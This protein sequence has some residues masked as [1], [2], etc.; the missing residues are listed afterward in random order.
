[1]IG[2]QMEG[3]TKEEI[4][5]P[6]YGSFVLEIDNDLNPADLFKGLD[7]KPVGK[8]L[9]E[10]MKISNKDVAKSLEGLP[11]MKMHCSNLAADAL[12]KAIEDY[13][14]SISKSHKILK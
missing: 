6:A 3:L 12:Q 4:L 7:I 10:A 1:M 5:D 11:P 14:N 8:T 13:K 9:E 2:A